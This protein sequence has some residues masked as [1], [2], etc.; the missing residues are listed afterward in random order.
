[1]ALLLKRKAAN[2]SGIGNIRILPG[3][4][5]FED[6]QVEEMKKNPAWEEMLKCGIHE[7]V[8]GKSEGAPA[9]PTANISEMNAAE[10]IK[11]VKNTFDRNA[12]QVMLEEEDAEKKRVAV[13]KAI[14]RQ[15]EE[16][17]TEPEED[18]D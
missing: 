10:A 1:M 12:L 15:I 11:I 13:L 14:D 6:E 4:N 5:R 17:T 3:I 8:T 2:V 16:F 9:E 7:I 18:E